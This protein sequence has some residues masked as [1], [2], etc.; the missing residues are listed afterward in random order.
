MS[1]YRI[2]DIYIIMKHKS[3]ASDHLNLSDRFN[4]KKY[5]ETVVL[6]PEESVTARYSPPEANRM[7]NSIELYSVAM[8]HV[9]PKIAVSDL[10]S[11]TSVLR[12]KLNS[13]SP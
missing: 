5:P 12:P 6:V 8:L 10:K 4:S 13:E 11:A 9:G 7:W 2:F 3:Q 1:G